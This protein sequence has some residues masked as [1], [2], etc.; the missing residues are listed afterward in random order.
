M[1]NTSP[2]TLTPP[3]PSNPPGQSRT[4]AKNRRALA[5]SARQNARLN[6]KLAERAESMAVAAV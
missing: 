3:G 1:Q 5:K 2:R 4:P 6:A